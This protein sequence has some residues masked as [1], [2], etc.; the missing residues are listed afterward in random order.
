MKALLDATYQRYDLAKKSYIAGVADIVQLSEAT[1]EY[2]DAQ[3][4]SVTS[5]LNL[6]QARARLDWALGRP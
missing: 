1:L 5:T 6:N 2:I 4:R 3:F